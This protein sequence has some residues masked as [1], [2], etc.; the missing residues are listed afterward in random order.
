MGCL[1]FSISV[2]ALAGLLLE[3]ARAHP[4]LPS[5]NPHRGRG[6][7]DGPGG[8]LLRVLAYPKSSPGERQVCISNLRGQIGGHLDSAVPWS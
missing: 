2:V 8:P 3:E 5:L 4:F 1:D 6:G 7:A